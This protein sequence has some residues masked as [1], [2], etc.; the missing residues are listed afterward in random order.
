M[1]RDGILGGLQAP[2]NVD[3]EFTAFSEQKIQSVF[4]S[5]ILYLVQQILEQVARIPRL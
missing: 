2:E 3:S 5:A 1:D 4:Q